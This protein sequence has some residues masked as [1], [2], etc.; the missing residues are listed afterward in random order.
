MACGEVPFS[1][2]PE[3]MQSF[4][5]YK[6][7]LCADPCWLIVQFRLSARRK[8]FAEESFLHIFGIGRCDVH[9]KAGEQPQRGDD[10]SATPAGYVL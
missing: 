10:P 5:P 1:P 6:K 8:A 4:A 2:H 9:P 7:G 3:S